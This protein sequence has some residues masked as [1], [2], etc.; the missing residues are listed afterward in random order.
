MGNW[1]LMLDI[2][3]ENREGL[4]DLLREMKFQFGTIIFKI[5]INEVYSM[6]KFSQMVIEYPELGRSIGSR[7]N[8]D[9]KKEK[10]EELQNKEQ[11]VDDYWS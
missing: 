9:D 3:I 2:E 5:E 11:K 7:N 6:E 10:N 1:Q 4:R 8:L